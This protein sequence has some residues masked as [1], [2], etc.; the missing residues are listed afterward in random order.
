MNSH[1]IATGLLFL[2]IFELMASLLADF[3]PNGKPGIQSAQIL[4]LEIAIILIV[5][6]IW[7]WL[8]EPI[9]VHALG[10]LLRDLADRFFT[11]SP[12][13]WVMTGFLIVYLLFFI[14]PIFLND[15]LRMRYF[16]NYLPD[17]YPVGGNLAIT[18]DLTKGWFFDHQSPY[19]AEFYPP[20]YLCALCASIASG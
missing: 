11:L 6:P 13:V 2:G 19:R 8:A 14:S 4:G 1:R 18:I 5:G 7:I 15:T 9:E 20:L 16:N 17:R 10:K 12:V 3:L